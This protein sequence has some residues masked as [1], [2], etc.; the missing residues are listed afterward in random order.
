[1]TSTTSFT[2]R[3]RSRLSATAFHPDLR[4]ASR[5][6]PPAAVAGPRSLAL[7]RRMSS[8]RPV[9]GAYTASVGDGETLVYRPR[10]AVRGGVLWI[11]G[12]GMVIGSPQQDARLCRRIAEDLD[13]VVVAPRYR[14][15]PEH[16]FPA[17]L[18]DCYAAL[19]WLAALQELADVP[20]VVAGAS[21]GGGL[22]A[23]VVLAAR[24]RGEVRIDKQVLVYP[25][26]DDRTAAGADPAADVRR[27][28]NN[29]ANAFGWR[30]YLGFAP[31]S[32]DVSPYAAPARAT[33]LAGLPP[34]WIGVG[35]SD[36]FHDEDVLYA[37]RLRAAGVPT[38][39]EVVPGAF[40]AFD[41]LPTEVSRGFVESYLRAIATGLVVA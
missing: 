25:M 20:L 8:H 35:T 4:T 29:T 1:M 10:G 28:W 16:P 32:A 2:G 22:A 30:S 9:A 23:G 38:D 33:D 40:H 18:E 34:T 27:V 13:A 7:S 19:R 15:A 14:L 11:H 41:G 21:A 5:V 37:E 36:L 3:L 17:P 26:L 31:G 12:G 24:D 6:L 39:L